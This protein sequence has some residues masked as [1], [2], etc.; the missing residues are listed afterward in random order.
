ME[1]FTK[2]SWGLLALLHLAPATAVFSPSV[3]GKLYGADPAGD[4][5][6][7]LIHRGA[8]FLAVLLVALY[9]IISVDARRAASLVAIVSMLGFLIV[10]ARAGMPAG[11]LKKIAVADLAGLLPLACV[12]WQAWR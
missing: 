10:Y 3:V 9:A 12:S 8:L 11:P 1:T 2:V 5:G 6:V 7:L 4:V